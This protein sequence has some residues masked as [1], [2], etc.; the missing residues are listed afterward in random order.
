[1]VDVYIS[2]KPRKSN[3]NYFGFVRFDFRNHAVQSLNG[4]FLDGRKILVSVA[5]YGRGTRDNRMELLNPKSVKTTEEQG[6]MS[7][8]KNPSTNCMSFKHALLGGHQKT[9]NREHKEANPMKKVEVVPSPE[10]KGLLN[11]SVVAESVKPIKFGCVVHRAVKQVGLA[12]LGPA[13]L[14]RFY[15]D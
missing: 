7:H 14:A 2:R 4:I 9:D 5:K 15:T 13:R 11:R 3:P 1:V 8:P 12:H 10:E 6:P